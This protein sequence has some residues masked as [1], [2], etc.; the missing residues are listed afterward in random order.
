MHVVS[1]MRP[2][3]LRQHH[4]ELASSASSIHLIASPSQ[5]RRFHFHTFSRVFPLKTMIPIADFLSP[6]APAGH[7]C[8]CCFVFFYS[9]QVRSVHTAAPALLLL[10]LLQRPPACSI[11]QTDPTQDAGPP[12]AQHRAEI[13]ALQS[14]PRFLHNSAK[15][16]PGWKCCFEKTERQKKIK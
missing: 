5:T 2:P 8:C 12:R 9:H 3:Q 1:S 4:C 11:M 16:K 15:I 14:I 10:L 13:E 6:L 7:I